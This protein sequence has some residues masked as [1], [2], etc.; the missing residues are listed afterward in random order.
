MRSIY[1]EDFQRWLDRRGSYDDY[2]QK[3]IA[4]YRAYSKG[5]KLQD[6]MDIAD[7]L[8][9]FHKN[10]VYRYTRDLVEKLKKTHFL[11]AIS[12]SPYHVVEPFCRYWG[13][14]KVYAM[15][16]EIDK[17]EIFTGKVE[18]EDFM[19][20]KDKVLMRA[21]KKEGLTLAGS[22]GVGDSESDIPML[23]MVSRAIAFNPNKK[24]YQAAKRN[25][26][27]IVVERKDMIY[28][29]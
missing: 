27:E 20:E 21:M 25:K 9:I 19:S 23:K 7:R 15:M 17:N 10:R 2:I 5:V 26:W 22:V 1:N 13:F 16:Y 8:M 14:Q 24:L 11:L 28:R 29:L 4:A 6:V 18:Y 3:V 12:H